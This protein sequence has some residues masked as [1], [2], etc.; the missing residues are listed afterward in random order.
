MKFTYFTFNKPWA[1]LS[2]YRHVGVQLA[3]HLQKYQPRKIK[4]F[5]STPICPI[6]VDGAMLNT[7]HLKC[8]YTIIM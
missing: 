4:G 6:N 5:A 7:R 1:I 3:T 8:V 2:R